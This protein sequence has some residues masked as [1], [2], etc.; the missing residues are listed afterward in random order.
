MGKL[1]TPKL[2]HM[3]NDGLF[4]FANEIERLIH[5]HYEV[6]PE[7]MATFV[8][9]VEVM[10]RAMERT[11]N[12]TLSSS[13][14][15]VDKSAAK[16]WRNIGAQLKVSLVH[17]EENVRAAAEEVW[18]IYGAVEN[19]TKLPYD[20]KFGIYER[21]LTQLN[22]VPVELRQT[23]LVHP[24]IEELRQNII[25]ATSLF[26]NRKANEAERVNGV[27]KT[28]RTNLSHAC[29]ELFEN[30]NVILR[31]RPSA[32]LEKFAN[33]L[34][35]LSEDVRQRLKARKTKRS[36]GTMSIDV[37]AEDD[38][39]IIEDDDSEAATETESEEN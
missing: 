4:G 9:L 21:L 39:K 17:P 18:K 7:F 12:N 5:K 20:T 1:L 2:S 38:G 3:T 33:E 24:W 8:D 31:L 13:I 16:D 23:A 25:V 30:I 37:D 14:G 34:S 35:E 11:L 15:S 26:L 28:A 32:Q 6:P 36:K 29:T 22:T 19:P 10:D 27:V